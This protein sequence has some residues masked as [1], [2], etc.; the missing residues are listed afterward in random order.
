MEHR[1]PAIFR[2]TPRNPGSIPKNPLAEYLPQVAEMQGYEDSVED[3]D[4]NPVHPLV[5]SK[6]IL[7]SH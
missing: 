2:I 6:L 7:F 1:S 5:Y 3:S 4:A